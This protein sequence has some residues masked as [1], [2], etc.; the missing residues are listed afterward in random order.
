MGLFKRKKITPSIGN[1]RLKLINDFEAVFTD[2]GG[3]IYSNDVVRSSIHAIA[4]NA[5]KL[6]IEH[7]GSAKFNN[8]VLTSPNSYMK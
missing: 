4:T 6:K 7:Q 5:A 2:F 1:T 3:D 8:I